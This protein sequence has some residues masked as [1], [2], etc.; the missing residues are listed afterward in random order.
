MNKYVNAHARP[1]M[2]QTGA[3]NPAAVQR[4]MAQNNMTLAALKQNQK[5]GPLTTKVE[6]TKD[7]GWLKDWTL[8]KAIKWAVLG[9][10]TIAVL[11]DN[12]D[13]RDH[14]NK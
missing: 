6:S 2:L 4:F 9:G 1:S 12:E 11:K 3:S 13:L 14:V 7:C 10:A 5:N 8:G